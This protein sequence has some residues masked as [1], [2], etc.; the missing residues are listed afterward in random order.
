MNKANKLTN[1]AFKTFFKKF[2][3]NYSVTNLLI[4]NEKNYCT[5]TFYLDF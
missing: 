3:F 4:K 1:I 5:C 2:T